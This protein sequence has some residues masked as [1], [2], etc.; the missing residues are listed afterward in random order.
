MVYKVSY[1]LDT[2]KTN[3]MNVNEALEVTELNWKELRENL[4]HFQYK[5]SDDTLK[6]K[7]VTALEWANF[8]LENDSTDYE[9]EIYE[10]Q[11]M[12]YL[13][14]YSQEEST[15]VFHFQDFM[16]VSRGTILSDIKTL[17]EKLAE[18]A[19][20]IFYDRQ[21]GYVLEGN[22][23]NMIRNAKNFISRL[24]ESE[25]GK[26][27]LHYFVSKIQLSLYAKVKD[28]I[29]YYI[30]QSNFRYVP[31]RIDEI[32]YFTIF[33][34][35]ILLS[36]AT[37]EVEGLD[38]IKEISIYQTSQDILNALYSSEISD[39]NVAIYT[40]CLLTILQGNIHEPAFDFLLQLSSEIIHNMEKLAA[41]KFE[42]FRTLLFDFYNH[43]VP[44][45]FR[46]K[47]NL[48]L[49]NIM[50]DTIYNEY[51]SIYNLTGKALLPLEKSTG[52]PIRDEEIGYFTILFGGAINSEDKAVSEVNQLKA[53][54]VCPNGI[55]SS[56]ILSTEL[57]KLFPS[58]EYYGSDSIDGLKSISKNN[59]DFIFSTVPI[60]T[61]K[62]VYVVKP[63][64]NQLE[65]NKLIN[66]VQTDW[67]LPGLLLPNVEEIVKSL[68]PYITLKEG[69]SKEQIY[70]ILNRKLSSNFV[71][72]KNLQL[73]DLLTEDKIQIVKKVNSW[74]DAIRVAAEPLYLDGSV[75]ISYI[76][77]MV[78]NIHTY[79]AYIYL[80]N[81][82]A[83]PHSAPEDGV[84]KT[85]ISLL[86]LEKP[87]KILNDP[88]YETQF[89]FV[90]AAVDNREHLNA[91]DDLMRIVDNKDHIASLSEATNEKNILDII[92]KSEL[93]D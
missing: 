20:E 3:S 73:R 63:I 49:S 26:F 34:K 38:K 36:N 25:N 30:S 91:L 74:E 82:I 81:G 16:G 8:F 87:I 80:G 45:Y 22:I 65:K 67:L 56:L 71:E 50:L 85:G 18:D 93:D 61:D 37:K 12:I 68:E 14:I 28:N 89:I 78:K 48:Y 79:G 76:E 69:V 72:D 23:N 43:L 52:K 39:T 55:S 6:I 70:R 66:E 4:D 10:R 44:A 42:D 86:K 41:I 83:L 57:K 62:K 40:I 90:L 75:E 21:K 58:I 5:L 84:N 64:M 53:M 88:A 24:I 60:Q 7:K 17:R 35:D 19:I 31:S 77:S 33:S 1:L 32:I 15:S 54:I 11:Y 92:R 13:M 59:Y 51:Y 2:E 46:I 47:Y 9:L 29:L 27:I